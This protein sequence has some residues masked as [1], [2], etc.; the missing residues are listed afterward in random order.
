MQ[1][2]IMFG[3]AGLVDGNRRTDEGGGQD[4]SAW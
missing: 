2:G 1:A 3:Y 4:Q